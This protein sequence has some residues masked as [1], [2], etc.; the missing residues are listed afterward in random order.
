MA[1]RKLELPSVTLFDLS[2]RD[3]MYALEEAYD[4]NGWASS[5]DVADTIGIVHKNPA[6]CIGSRFAWW[7]RNGLVETDVIEGERVW[8]M[9]ELGKTIMKSKEVT[10][11]VMDALNKLSEGQ[12]VRFIEDVAR[13]VRTGSNSA[14]F[15][16]KRAWR[17]NLVTV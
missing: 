14:A 11:T 5:K 3:L 9:S 12:R 2:D 10:K 8:K 16:S 1:K 15:V 4:K 7:R 6:G 13:Q 17:R